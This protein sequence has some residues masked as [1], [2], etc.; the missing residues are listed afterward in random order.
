MMRWEHHL[1]DSPFDSHRFCTFCTQHSPS[2]RRF[3]CADLNVLDCN[4]Q[5]GN[6]P[7]LT[8]NICLLPHTDGT[9]RACGATWRRRLRRHDEFPDCYIWN[10]SSSFTPSIQVKTTSLRLRSE[11]IV[12]CGG[13]ASPQIFRL[14]ITQCNP[15]YPRG[16]ERC[17]MDHLCI[18][19]PSSP[20]RITRS[21]CIISHF[22]LW[23]IN[24]HEI[25]SEQCTGIQLLPM[26]IANSFGRGRRYYLEFSSNY[27]PTA[28]P[29]THKSG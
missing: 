19:S 21:M 3:E 15:G 24:I 25:Q 5:V 8:Q 10:F 11:S 22:G 14:K 1:L 18:K 7:L 6:P 29:L 2:L 4:G 23:N 16:V 26:K 27:L 28:T 17:D 13:F 9:R 12:K 20:K